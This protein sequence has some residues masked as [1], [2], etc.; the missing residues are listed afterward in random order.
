MRKVIHAEL[1]VNS[2]ELPRLMADWSSCVRFAYRRFR[3]GLTFNEVRITAKAKY[4]ILS[5]RQVSDAVTEAKGK[6]ECTKDSNPIVFGGKKLFAKVCAGKVSAE[7]WRFVRDGMMY[8]RGDRTKNGNPTL[9]V[10]RNTDGY[11]L[12]VVVGNR[13]FR[14]YSLFVPHKFTETLDALLASGIAYNIRIRRKDGRRCDVTIDHEVESP[15]LRATFQNGCV[16]VDTNPDRIAICLVAPD[17]NRVWSRAL[18]N[19][20]MFY[21]SANKTQY[22][23]ALL[24]K[25]IADLALKNGCGIA[26][27]NLKFKPKFVKG[28]SKS[29]RMK[30]RF[31][32]RSF[33]ALLERK[34]QEKGIEFRKVNPA[35]TSVQGKLKYH[36]MFN[37]S[38]HE[39]A[40]YVIGRRALGFNEKLSI[41]RL[42]HREA[43]KLAVAQTMQEAD[44]RPR[45]KYHSWYLWKQLR[46]IASLTE[47]RPSLS[48]PRE[49][50]GSVSNGRNCGVS[51]QGESCPITGRT[52]SNSNHQTAGLVDNGLLLRPKKGGLDNLAVS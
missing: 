18:V 44:D 13:D 1:F 5:T 41:Y 36:Q 25:E 50:D 42:P 33:L 4:L 46:N 8:A 51:P 17:G 24:V 7:Q 52:R 39:A 32:W 23:V 11:Y 6:Y 10:I 48:N 9:R 21:G 43:R 12:R 19:A 47:S 15:Q 29:N 31:I 27:E 2:D 3:E 16:G 35:F 26:A 14:F 37:V 28:W 30:S 20:R 22:E 49:L 38:I 45:R 40:A 34:C